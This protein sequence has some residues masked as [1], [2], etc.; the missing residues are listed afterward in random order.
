VREH[1]GIVKPLRPLDVETP[2]GSHFVEGVIDLRDG[3]GFAFLA[4]W[5]GHGQPPN[6]PLHPSQLVYMLNKLAWARFTA[7]LASPEVMRIGLTL[8]CRPEMDDADAESTAFLLN[9]VVGQATGQGVQLEGEAE[10]D[11]LT[12]RGAYTLRGYQRLLGG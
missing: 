10:A 2:R 1:W 6:S 7:D 5:L 11:G 4:Q 3:R 8:E 9:S 12:V